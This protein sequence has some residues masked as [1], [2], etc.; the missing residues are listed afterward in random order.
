M[1]DR[2]STLLGQKTRR[3]VGEEERPRCQRHS[4]SFS[5]YVATHRQLIGLRGA[6]HAA[7]KLQALQLFDNE[8]S[9]ANRGKPRLTHSMGCRER[10]RKRC[11]KMQFFFFKKEN[12]LL[13]ASETESQVMGWL[14]PCNHELFMPARKVRE[15]WTLSAPPSHASARLFVL[16]TVSVAVLHKQC[17]IPGRLTPS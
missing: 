14:Q 4:R 6:T 8:L 10:P 9:G 15:I 1:W 7:V 12:F 3:A 13:S 2:S 17:R 11:P 16:V 5:E